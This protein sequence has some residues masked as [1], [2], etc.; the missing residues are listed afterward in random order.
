MNTTPKENFLLQIKT[1]SSS[2]R[3][4]LS[5]PN[6]KAEAQVAR[7]SISRKE[8]QL[9]NAVAWC[10]KHNVRGYSAVKCGLFPL[11][12][13]TRTI[14]TWL[15]GKIITG[16]DAVQYVINKNRAYQGINKAE[17]TKLIINVPI[18]KVKPKKSV[19]NTRVTQI[20]G[21]MER[22]DV[23]TVVLEN[24][25]LQKEEKVL[26]KTQREERKQKERKHSTSVKTNAILHNM[27]M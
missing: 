23:L 12:K 6:N 8:E 14:D 17:L 2:E 18:A 25:K 20:C 19:Q 21:S 3:C 7:K 13:N 15:D 27:K 9:D 11:V 16:Q 10:R 24:L 5:N 4:R 22:K 26:A 1:P